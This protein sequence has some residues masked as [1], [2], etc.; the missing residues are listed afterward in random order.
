M[1]NE[2]YRKKELVG[3]TIMCIIIIGFI[4]LG[5]LTITGSFS[6]VASFKEKQKVC[7]VGLSEQEVFVRH[8]HCSPFLEECSY[9]VLF[10]Q[11]GSAKMYDSELEVCED[12][13]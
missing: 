2:E 6:P 9:K 4:A 7:V 13:N 3:C 8:T 10:S 12:N 11:G 5:Y 1:S